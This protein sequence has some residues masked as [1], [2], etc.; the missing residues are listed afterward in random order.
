V[1]IPFDPHRLL[2]YVGLSVMESLAGSPV[3]T[4]IGSRRFRQKGRVGNMS[5]DE[6][7]ARC[8]REIAQI[9][10]EAH[11]GNPDIRG[12]IQGLHDWRTERLLILSRRTSHHNGSDEPEF[13][14]TQ[15]PNGE[16]VNG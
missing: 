16:K 14:T 4:Q 7:L 13:N 10:Q 1:W 3:R 11:S 2:F 15:I 6:D 5:A 12:M 9:E 8:D